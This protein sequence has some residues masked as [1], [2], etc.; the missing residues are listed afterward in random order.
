[1]ASSPHEGAL[2]VVGGVGLGKT[3]LLEAALEESHIKAVMVRINPADAAWPLSGFFTFLASLSSPHA[4]DIG[5]GMALTSTE[6]AQMFAAAR[7]ILSLVQ[8]LGL[9]PILLLLD[10][11]HLMD[12]TSQILVGFM[13]GR[14]RGTGIRLVATSTG[15]DPGGRFGGLPQLHLD[16]L[17]RPLA[18][19]FARAARPDSRQSGSLT[20]IVDQA[21]RNP[22]AILEALG[23]VTAEQLDGLQPLSLP[24][25]PG[26]TAHAHARTIE[27]TLTP[28]QHRLLTRLSAAPMV[29]TAAATRGTI[30]DEDAL[31]DLVFLGIA[32][33][34]GREVFIKKPLLRSHV[35]WS[36]TS[37]ARRELHQTEADNSSGRDALWHRSFGTA[38]QSNPDDLLRAAVSLAHGG[39]SRVAVEFADRALALTNDQPSSLRRVAQLARVLFESGE[40]DLASRYVMCGLHLTTSASISLEL[41]VLR[42]IIDFMS[43]QRVPDIELE[44]WDALY[45]TDFPEETAEMLA[46]AAICRGLR[47]ELEPA[48][49]LLARAEAMMPPDGGTRRIFN[50]ATRLLSATTGQVG[51]A[52]E[53]DDSG[54]FSDSEDAASRPIVDLLIDA[55][56]CTL[57]EDYAEASRLCSIILNRRPQAEPVWAD[58]ARYLLADN[59]LRSGE[60]TTARLSISEWKSRWLPGLRPAFH[61]HLEAWLAYTEDRLNDADA[62]VSAELARNRYGRSPALSARLH[63]LRGE[64]ALIEG[65][66]E[67]STRMLLMADLIDHDTSNPSLVRHIPDLV[68][69]HGLANRWA[70]ARAV[71][72]SFTRRVRDNPSR[73]ARIALLQAKPSAIEDDAGAITSC[74]EALDSIPAGSSMLQVAR[75]HASKATRLLRLDRALDATESFRA[76]LDAF[77]IAGARSWARKMEEALSALASLPTLVKLKPAL[78]E[79]GVDER[80]VAE[81]VLKGY[82]NKEIAAELFVS[83]RTV[84]ARLTH[85]YRSVGAS[86][87]SQLVSLMS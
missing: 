14:L 64:I 45:A 72:E 24:L 49:C 29:D 9:P 15:A 25:V 36:L 12:Q 78:V 51:S 27:A 10:D 39:A 66:V 81:L 62:I 84:E 58:T 52:I 85:I 7:D 38:E 70:E 11:V 26:P 48:R 41:T 3:K 68:E 61:S 74:D 33:I 50:L 77:D 13:A 5:A 21:E 83:V 79:L 71:F 44:A 54:E 63:A 4:M 82:R 76:A 47:W 6:P 23:R 60:L 59:D 32:E 28:A 8:G 42:L 20:I 35:Y 17:S 19:D 1:M 18:L 56:S 46:L 2:L 37:Q 57:R 22:R 69:A 67:K 87:R 43:D 40:L 86:S 31:Q 80:A 30:D 75:I 65:D 34:F 55:R 73:W 53:L 16:P